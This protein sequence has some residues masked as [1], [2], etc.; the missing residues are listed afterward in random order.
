MNAYPEGT[1]RD[2]MSPIDALIECYDLWASGAWPESN[3]GPNLDETMDHLG[4]L[5]GENP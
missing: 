3:S 2:D 4:R 5:L 1:H